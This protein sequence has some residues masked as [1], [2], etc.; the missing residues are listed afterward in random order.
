MCVEVESDSVMTPDTIIYYAT[1]PGHVAFR[2]P[3]KGSAFI[4]AICKVTLRKPDKFSTKFE[5]NV[6]LSGIF[7]EIW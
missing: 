1:L 2:H 3:E 7:L 5:I 6:I 4:S